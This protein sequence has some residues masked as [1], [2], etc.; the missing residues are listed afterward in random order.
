MPPSHS[1]TVYSDTVTFDVRRPGWPTIAAARRASAAVIAVFAMLLVAGCGITVPTDPNGTLDSVTG[2]TLHAGAS[3]E[4][5]LVD[6]DGEQPQGPLVELVEDFAASIDARVEWTVAAEESLVRELE[7]GDLDLA[8]GGFTDQTPWSDRAGVTRGYS[9]I[10]GA[11]DRKLV[12][13]VPLGENAFLS[14]LE[15]FLDEE[16]GS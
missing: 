6:T 16:V 7:A 5:G 15:T 14:S 10:P 8:V 3:P 1:D 13:L 4:A 9:N 2:S 12:F 11:D